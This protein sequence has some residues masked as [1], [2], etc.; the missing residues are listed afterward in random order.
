MVA[1]VTP[2]GA[3][4]GAGVRVGDVVRGSTAM[5]MQMVY[6]TT[7]LLFGG[8]GTCA[9][10]QAAAATVGTGAAQRTRMLSQCQPQRCLLRAG[11]GRPKLVKVLVPTS[12]LAFPKVLDAVRSN[13]AAA[14]GDDAIVLVLER[15]GDDA[16][17]ADAGGEERQQAEQQREAVLAGASSG[18]GSGSSSAQAGAVFDPEIF[19]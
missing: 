19:Q 1:E 13:S 5:M 15:I 18:G 6:P 3:A 17:G 2:G 7:N 11:V 12:K 8:E 4:D 16:D 10:C 14:G 9:A